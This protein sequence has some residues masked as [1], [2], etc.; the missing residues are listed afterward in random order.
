M[1][2]T[3]NGVATIT[4]GKGAVLKNY[5]GM[6][7]VRI[8]GG[9]FIMEA[10]SQ[11]IDDEEITREK[12]S[13]GSFGPAG[14]V[15]LQGGTLTMEEGSFIG[16]ADAEN[17]MSG[18]A[19]YIDGGKAEVN[20]TLQ[21]LKA[22]PEM[23]QGRSGV[24]FHVRSDGQAVLGSTGVIDTLESDVHAGYTGAVMTNGDRNEGEK[25][26]GEG[27]DFE[28]KAGSVIR[29]VTGFPAVFSNYGNELLDG[30]IEDC[31]N[32]YIV[33][34]FAQVTT[35]GKNGLIQNC[36]TTQGA[37]KSVIY[38]SNASDIY[39]NGTVKGN[40]VGT[41]A[42]YI[43][44]QSGGGAYLEIA[45]GALIE[46]MG[47]NY[48]V[49]INASESKCVMNGGTITGFDYGVN[50]RGKSGRDATFIMNG[51]TITGNGSGI[52]FNGISNSQSIVDL[53]GGTI[54]GNESYEVNAYGGN[55]EDAYE[56]VKISSGVVKGSRS[57]RLSAGTLT[58]DEAYADIQLGDAKSIADNKIE[59]LVKAAH[60]DWEVTSSSALWIK[61]SESEVRFMITAPYST[62]K[63]TMYAATI[64]LT[65][66]GEPADAAELVL[67]PVENTDPIEVTL[68]GLEA[69]T[70]YAMMFVNTNIYR[71]APDDITIYTGGGQDSE[72][73]YAET[74]GL[75][76]VTLSNSLD[77]IKEMTVNGAP[78]ENAS[79]D[80]LLQYLEVSYTDL[81]GNPIKDDQVP[82][83]YRIHLAWKSPETVIKINGNAW[84]SA[85][86]GTII[87]LP[88]PEG[89]SYGDTQNGAI[90]FRLIH[91]PELH[92]EYGISG[93][94]NCR[95]HLCPL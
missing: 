15:W 65:A 93:Q 44:N 90:N 77:E 41:S 36:D 2:A 72:H 3:Y 4:L 14:A 64:P 89:T 35:I 32:D 22:N 42:F 43:I 79:V 92:R 67:T 78:V 30:T 16:G 71:L 55:S 74:G 28:A 45:E 94:G 56:R 49:Y 27:Y 5:G 10:G 80:T 66:T 70:P 50:C 75:P 1:I 34:G 82:G 47:S 52:Y 39:M 76:K 7:A 88:Y 87:Y 11:I 91:Y 60:P 83:E 95:I 48:G 73:N 20:G 84:V 57:V 68:S 54:E 13:D 61:P 53:N 12:G 33:G 21:Y 17:P 81:D 24:A 38:T 63:T 86:Y 26:E 19:V 9:E 46:G 59:E 29:N 85:S 25:N 31:T 51:G 69:G 6:C 23:W 18:R 8:S 37:A 58:L 62:K 40:K